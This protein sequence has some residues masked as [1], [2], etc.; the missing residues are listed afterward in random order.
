MQYKKKAESTLA[1][2]QERASVVLDRSGKEK[3]KN[4]THGKKVQEIL[5]QTLKEL[6]LSDLPEKEKQTIITVIQNPKFQNEIYS[7]AKDDV[8][9]ST[10]SIAL[11]LIL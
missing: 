4:D 11:S 8:I 3:E 6:E 10:K 1:I 2:T 5:T 9:W 7:L